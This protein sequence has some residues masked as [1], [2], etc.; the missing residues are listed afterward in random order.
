[1]KHQID[2]IVIVR[3]STRIPKFQQLLKD[4]FDW[5][6]LNKGKADAYGAALQGS[7]LQSFVR[8]LSPSKA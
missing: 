7:I 8:L 5:K 1:M 3:G 4:Y 2:E 6:D